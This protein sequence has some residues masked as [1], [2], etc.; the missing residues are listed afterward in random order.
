MSNLACA[1]SVAKARDILDHILTFLL[2]LVFKRQVQYLFMRIFTYLLIT[3][4]TMEDE[5][6]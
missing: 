5:N 3:Y 4:V 1:S 2:N 6:K